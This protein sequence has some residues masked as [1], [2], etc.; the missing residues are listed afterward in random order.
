MNDLKIKKNKVM[1][2]WNE[3]V[4]ETLTSA[5]YY[6]VQQYIEARNPSLVTIIIVIPTITLDVLYD[7]VAKTSKIW[8]KTKDTWI[9]N[10]SFVSFV[11]IKDQPLIYIGP[12]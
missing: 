1:G 3:V 5:L 9:S 2:K 6:I 8:Q 7:G 4:N 12:S 10:D 11:K